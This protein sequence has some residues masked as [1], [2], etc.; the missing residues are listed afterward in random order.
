VPPAQIADNLAHRLDHEVAR[1]RKAGRAVLPL[2]VGDP[3]LGTPAGIREA[4]VRALSEGRTHYAPPAGIAR[5]REAIAARWTERHRLSVSADQVVVLPAKFAIYA[6]LLASVD[7]GDEVLFADPSY[8][9]EEPVRL[10]GARPV[11]FSLGRDHE[12]DLGALNDAITPKTRMLVLVTPGNPTGRLLRKDE[13]KAATQIAADRG[14]TVLSDEAYS[15]VVFEGTHVPSAS[16][17]P[18]GLPVITVG[19]F[20]KTYAMSGWRAGFALA[21][22]ELAQRLVRVVEHTITCVPPFVQEA[23]AWA[24]ENAESEHAKLLDKLRERRDVLLGR[25]DDLAGI[26]YVAPDGAIYVFPRYEPSIPSEEFAGRLLAEEGVAV[27]PGA[28]F[29]PHGERH[30]RIAYAVPPEKLDEAAERLGAF[31]E[32]LGAVRG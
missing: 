32:R 1:L 30:V 9:F 23:C 22:P 13:L 29:G 12:L 7:P 8:F 14:L 4:A 5:L 16:V 24:L 15:E 26:S 25:L 20:S 17:A 31:L 28:A 21:P 11:R 6:A 19:S 18:E 2:H 3:E 10:V 27:A